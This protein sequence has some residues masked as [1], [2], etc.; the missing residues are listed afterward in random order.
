MGRWSRRSVLAGLA[1]A[2]TLGGCQQ[3]QPDSE[4]RQTLTAAAVPEANEPRGQLTPAAADCPRLPANAEAYIC[5]PNVDRDSNLRLV[6][7]A[8]EYSVGTGGLVF[9]L[10][11]R[12]DS[13]FRTGRDWW[14]L[15]VRRQD[16]W[17]IVGQGARSDDVVVKPGGVF[18]WILGGQPP[19]DDV[20]R[21]NVDFGGGLHALV[22]TGYAAGGT[23]TAVIAPI[24]VTPHLG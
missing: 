3:V 10:V 4:G 22:V 6:P 12:T 16:G 5:S 9:T 17:D 20:P 11:N 14:T 21:L 19:D 18:V 7:E 8:T 1:G 2:L 13:E 15:S 24:Q 23:L